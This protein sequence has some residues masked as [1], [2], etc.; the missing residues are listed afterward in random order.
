MSAPTMSSPSPV[1]V[2]AW[3]VAIAAAAL[4]MALLPAPATG[5]EADDQVTSSRLAGADRFATAASIAAATFETADVAILATGERFPDAL[6]ASYAAGSED[7]PVLLTTRADLPPATLDALRALQVGT[8]VLIGGAEA[9]GEEVESRL[10]EEGYDTERIHGADR[11]E[12]AAAVATTYGAGLLPPLPLQ[13][14]GSAIL[15][16]GE[17]FPD[18][19]AAGPLAAAADLPLLLTPTDTPHE[20]VD[21]ALADMGTGHLIVVG[22]TAAVSA[23]VTDHYE[24]QGYEVSRLAGTTRTHTATIV[25][26]H[27]IEHVEGFSR[28]AVLLARGD[29]FPDALA[30]GIHGA[31]V[32][33]PILLTDSPASL[34]T[35][36]RGW[37]AAGCPEVRAIHALGGGGAVTDLTLR[38]AVGAA[39]ACHQPEEP[40]VISSFT[41]PLEPGQSRNTNIHQA[42]DY[43]D[44]DVIEPGAAYSLNEGIGPRTRERGFIENGYIDDGETRSTVGGGVSQ[45]GTTFMNAAWFAGIHLEEFKP[46][47][48]YFERYPMCREA[49]LAWNS[50]DVVV[51][52]DTPS[53]ITIST[54]YSESHITISLL[55]QPWASVESWTSEPYDVEGSGG[56]FSVD[57]GR[58]ITY[59]DGAAAE[60]DYTWRYDEG[61]PG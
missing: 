2:S 13:E 29:D 59:P 10:Q 60:E 5:Q 44:G 21:A 15:A 26:D 22:G 32:G 46:H 40:V 3:I 45:V 8:V 49:T 36:T 25:A 9:I 6:A 57:C 47:S 48:I 14:G 17:D 16:S 23:A 54:D 51:V 50:L 35:P 38:S 41:T 53:R 4:A 39:M 1:P 7:G 24:S 58:T 19:L 37:L 43:I 61:Y 27:L 42:A 11:F 56:A 20:A 31:V 34:S 28:E 55:G 52:N 12:T 18:A 30:A 33:A